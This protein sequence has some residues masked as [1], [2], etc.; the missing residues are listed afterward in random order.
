[1]KPYRLER[2][3]A[4]GTVSLS[5]V[6]GSFGHVNGSIALPKYWELASLIDAQEDFFLKS[7]YF[8][9]DNEFIATQCAIRRDT[10]GISLALRIYL[11]PYDLPG[12]QGRLRL[13]ESKI[14]VPAR[15]YMRRLLSRISKSQDDWEWT[16]YASSSTS[17]PFL[18][19][20]TVRSLPVCAPFIITLRSQDDRT[21]A[22]LYSS[23]DSPAPTD[24]PID[25]DTLVVDGRLRGMNSKLY[26]YQRRS[27][28]AMLCKELP[29]NSSAIPDPLYIS[30]RGIDGTIMYLQPATLE[31]LAE[32]PIITTSKGG[33][34]CEELGSY[35]QKTFVTAMI[36]DLHFKELGRQ[37]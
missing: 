13:R 3:L 17:T 19:E 34:L 30:L 14:L 37:S 6:E 28:E 5:L 16:G 23:L 9:L 8:L 2:F 35:L 1:M 11:I 21:M 12:V 36:A 10:S 18:P 24:V 32:R 29:G 20:E 26:P 33:I 25:L 7:L 31:L 4:A 22:E 27:V 15:R